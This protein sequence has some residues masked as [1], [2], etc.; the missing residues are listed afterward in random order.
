MV[1]GTSI[2]YVYLPR[3]LARSHF[4]AHQSRKGESRVVIRDFLKERREG[5]TSR[6]RQ[7]ATHMKDSSGKVNQTR[8]QP[9]TLP[10]VCIPV[11]PER[12][13]ITSDGD[14][15]QARRRA[16]QLAGKAGFPALDLALIATIVSELAHNILQHAGSGEILIKKVHLLNRAGVVVVARDTG[17][18]IV[19]VTRALQDGFSTS[20]R[21]GLGLPI[22]KRVADEFKIVSRRN[23][24]TTIIIKKWAHRNSASRSGASVGPKSP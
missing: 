23:H 15:L 7:T 3:A 6:R 19:D 11:Q 13:S 10:G 1:R 4:Q 2:C 5:P 16:R 17:P 24:G 9:Q 21:M 12:I 22:V 14:I 20:G 8:C 18:G